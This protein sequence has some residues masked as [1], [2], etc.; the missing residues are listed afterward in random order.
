M[1]QVRVQRIQ[2]PPIG[3]QPIEIVERKGLGHPD[4]ICD[5]VMEEIA[6]A[7]RGSVIRLRNSSS[8]SMK[9]PFDDIRPSF[10]GVRRAT[11][12]SGPTPKPPRIT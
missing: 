2:Q 1:P 9:M 3:E 11:A 7:M 10:Y 12:R 8:E 4:S 6:V 5:A